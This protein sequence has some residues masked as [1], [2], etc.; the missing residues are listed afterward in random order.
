MSPGPLPSYAVISP[1]R[2]EAADLG[3]LAESL[4]A[5]NHPPLRWVIVD[6]GSTDR[7]RAIAE[8]YA[9]EHD[10]ITV[11]SSEERH[12]RERGAPIVRAFQQGRSLLCERPNIVVKLD[13]DL[14]LPAHYFATVAGTFASDPRAGI[15]G[16]VLLVQDRGQW[17]PESTRQVVGALKAYRTSCLDDIGGLHPS[18]GWDGID[19]YAARARGWTVHVLG[20]LTAT[21]HKRRGSKQRWHR[22][23]W[24]EGRGNHYMGYTASF[25]VVRAL[26]R[27]AVDRPRVFGGL[28]LATGFLAARLTGAPRVD[29]APAVALLRQEQ[30]AQLRA[31]LCG[32]WAMSGARPD[33][34]ASLRR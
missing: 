18:M 3:R 24:E 30:R 23:R 21:H 13:G 9:A 16:G 6:D 5:Q 22:A 11:V 17:R 7:T 1:V 33:S 31:L 27:M 29:D 26:Y 10:W 25:L 28:V 12:D 15:V 2:D 4:V 20:G 32:H 8:A 14:S 19:E 34:G